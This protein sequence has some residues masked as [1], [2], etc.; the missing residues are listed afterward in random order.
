MGLAL[1]RHE[2]RAMANVAAV[3]FVIGAVEAAAGLL[4]WPDVPADVRTAL[5]V[6]IVVSTAGAVVHGIFGPRLPWWSP[7]GGAL[8]G[9]LTLLYMCDRLWGDA[10]TAPMVA[11]LVLIELTVAAF[12]GRWPVVAHLAV[13]NLGWLVVC[14]R[15]GDV[16][17]VV[18]WWVAVGPVLVVAAVTVRWLV[19]RL[20]GLVE[21]DPLTGAANRATWN[22]LAADPGRHP[23]C[24]AVIDLDHFKRVNDEHGH[25]AGDELLRRVAEAWATSLR[26]TDVLA[27]LGGDEFAVVLPGLALDQGHAV[28]ERLRAQVAGFVSTTI[29]VAARVDAE[30][31]AT[32]FERADAALYEAKRAGRGRV[33]VATALTT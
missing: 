21:R 25:A 23:A 26:S 30:P 15:H 20:L 8:V 4:L 32:V 17:E 1:G 29:G 12:F 19:G 31:L 27:R 18:G 14:A 33:G 11:Q 9:T 24:V 3:Q 13:A 7:Y 22:R 28:A 10:A 6:A 5:V 2:P 16:G